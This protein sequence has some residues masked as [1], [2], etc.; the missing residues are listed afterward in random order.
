MAASR[1][2]PEGGLRAPFGL[3]VLILLLLTSEVGYQDLAALLARQQPAIERMQKAAFASPFGTIHETRFNFP[4]PVGASIPPT[5]DVT[6]VAHDQ[7]DITGSIRAIAKDVA[8]AGPVV[9]RS[10]KGDYGIARSGDR[11]IALKGDRLQSAP[12][13]QIAQEVAPETKPAPKPQVAARRER[14]A[15]PGP[16]LSLAPPA[17]SVESD[18]EPAPKGFALASAGESRPV[19]PRQLGGSRAAYPV[20]AP[21]REGDSS[22]DAESSAEAESD[23]QPVTSLGFASADADQTLRAARIYFSI[24]PMGQKLGSLEPWAPGQEPKFEDAEDVAVGPDRTTKG[25]A[26]V[27]LAALPPGAFPSSE[28]ERFVDAPVERADLPPLRDPGVVRKNGMTGGQTIAP[29]GEVTGADKQPM[30]PAQR[31]NLDEKSRAK[32]EKC[33]TEAIYF[34]ARGEPVKGE[35]AVAQVVINRLKNPA[36][37]NTICGVVYQNKDMR[38]ACQF[39]FACDGIKDRVAG[40]EHYEMAEEVAL[41]VTSGKIWIAEVGSS[42]HYHATYVRPRWARTMEK[43]MKIGR[44]IFYRTH[45]GGW[46]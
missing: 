33:L 19:S 40:R 21:P 32:S 36:Y 4:Q 16:P 18:D 39:S 43:M 30:T 28:R 22:R 31:L 20:L 5:L 26:N 1:N 3:G 15:P 29:K 9:D 7:S 46:S 37:P 35:L 25:D 27:K 8:G 11:V 41:A 12:P 10:G 38:D 42:T 17:A 13:N 44:H 24:D 6:L 45:G 34:E 14:A 23:V 2:R